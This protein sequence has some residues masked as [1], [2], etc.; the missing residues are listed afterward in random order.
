MKSLLKKTIVYILVIA[1]FLQTSP[2]G[3]ASAAEAVHSYLNPTEDIELTVPKNLQ[4]GNNYVF[5]RENVWSIS[6]K[7]GEKLYIP[8]QR[9]G[10]LSGEADVELKVIDI[11]ARHG[12]NYDIEIGC[13]Y[14]SLASFS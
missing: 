5:I 1:M 2:D 13:S 12:V 4:D 7:S 9:T 3:M 11:T 6:E 14:K 10:D 8:V